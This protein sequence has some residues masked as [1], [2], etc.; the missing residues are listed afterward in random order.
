MSLDVV[1]HRFA[2]DG[3][4]VTRVSV[5]TSSDGHQSRRRRKQDGKLVVDVW[6]ESDCR[7]RFTL[8]GET[9]VSRRSEGRTA[10]REIISNTAQRYGTDIGLACGVGLRNFSGT[11]VHSYCLQRFL[12]NLRRGPI[13]VGKLTFGVA[14]ALVPSSRN[15]SDPLHCPSRIQAAVEKEQYDKSH[16]QAYV[17]Q[18]IFSTPQRIGR[19]PR[20]DDAMNPIACNF[21]TR[22]LSGTMTAPPS[23]DPARVWSYKSK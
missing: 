17:D 21:P 8:H 12:T 7:C 1:V 18:L 22:C 23:R 4:V 13:A 10:K 11:E 3:D 9:C 16:P 5:M 15:G 14:H 19:T 6:H 2:I 20:G